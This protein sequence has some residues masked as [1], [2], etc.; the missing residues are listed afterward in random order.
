[1]PRRRRAFRSKTRRSSSAPAAI[2]RVSSRPPHKRKTWHEE[3]MLEAIKAVGEGCTISQ[4]ARDYG[5]PK[6]T[7]Y[8]RV[9]GKSCMALILGQNRT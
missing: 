1:M 6:T 2:G 5:V 8:D 9:S 7:L 4:T 3:S